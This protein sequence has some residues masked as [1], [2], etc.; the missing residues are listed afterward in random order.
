[1]EFPGALKE[2]YVEIP[3]GQ[4]K[5]KW[6]FQGY[7]EKIMWSFHGSRLA[8]RPWNFQGVSSYKFACKISRSESLFYLEFPGVK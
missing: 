4:L 2:E 8:F 7:E 5:K 6:N 3:G 1:M